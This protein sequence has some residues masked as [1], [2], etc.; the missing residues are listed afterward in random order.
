MNTKEKIE[1][2]INDLAKCAE[3]RKNN[4]QANYF[5]EELVIIRL[6]DI[7]ETKEYGS[8]QAR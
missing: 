4:P 2:L 6:K 7:L 8:D 1:L 3:K 5:T